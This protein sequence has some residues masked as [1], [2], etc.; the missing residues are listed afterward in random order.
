MKARYEAKREERE[1]M[2]KN[3]L[4]KM[5]QK[6]RNNKK[7]KK[8]EEEELFGREDEKGEQVMKSRGKNLKR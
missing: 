3:N 1:K 7:K 5:S 6:N 8:K 2:T 4:Q